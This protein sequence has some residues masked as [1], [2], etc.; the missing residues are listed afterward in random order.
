MIYTMVC[1]MTYSKSFKVKWSVVIHKLKNATVAYTAI[2][3]KIHY[4]RFKYHRPTFKAISQ[5]TQTLFIC[6]YNN[7]HI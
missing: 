3:Y 2:E 4:Q 1:I 7:I 6:N 5:C